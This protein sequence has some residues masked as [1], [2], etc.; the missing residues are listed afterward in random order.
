MGVGDATGSAWWPARSSA[1]RPASGWRPTGARSRTCRR[2]GAAAT[3]S[4]RSGR[5]AAAAARPRP[6]G[7][8]E[9]ARPS[10]TS[11]TA[12]STSSTSIRIVGLRPVPCS[13]CRSRSRVESVGPPRGLR[14]HQ[15]GLRQPLRGDRRR[16]LVGVGADVD[17][18]VLGHRDDLHALALD[19]RHGDHRRLQPAAAQ[20]LLDLGRVLADQLHPDAGVAGQHV[21]DQPRAGVQP[22]RPEHAEPDRAG[23]E[24]LHP[25]RRQPGLLGGGERALGVRAQGVGDGRGYDPAADPAEERDAE[26]L[27]EASDLLGH[28]RLRVAELLGGPR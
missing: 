22:C 1:G 25:L 7:I 24:P 9:S 10:P 6:C 19:L 23:L 5:A 11:S 17:D 8:T 28:R 27:L 21:G 3:P 12:I 16:E 26:R 2:G 18:L 13:I 4:R 14:H 15:R 20:V